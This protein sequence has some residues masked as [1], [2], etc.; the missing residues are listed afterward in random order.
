MG[1]ECAIVHARASKPGIN[2][3]DCSNPYSTQAVAGEEM[4]E[5]DRVQVSDDHTQKRI[6][7]VHAHKHQAAEMTAGTVGFF[8]FTG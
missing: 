6:L 3:L 7:H 2:V 1:T 5:H 4:G 8:L